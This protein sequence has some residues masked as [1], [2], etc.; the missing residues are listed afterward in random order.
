[1]DPE[2][3]NKCQRIFAEFARTNRELGHVAFQPYRFPSLI[4]SEVEGCLATLDEPRGARPMV[5]L[6]SP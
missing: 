1:M 3:E 6:R 2:N 5:R 4:L